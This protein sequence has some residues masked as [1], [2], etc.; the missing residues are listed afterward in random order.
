MKT[1]WLL[2]Y[3]PIIGVMLDNQVQIRIPGCLEIYI[4]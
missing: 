1:K 4:I 3:A 2:K